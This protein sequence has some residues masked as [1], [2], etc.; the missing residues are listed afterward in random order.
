[1]MSKSVA[2]FIKS[3]QL[4]KYRKQEQLFLVEGLKSTLEVINSHFNVRTVLCTEQFYE[5]FS[6]QLKGIET[7]L[8]TENQLTDVGTLRS[9]NAA[10]AVVEIPV[11]KSKKL[12]TNK[13]YLALDDINDPGNLGTILRVA[14]WYGIDTI[15]ASEQTAELY[16]P[17]VISASKGSFTRVEVIYGDLER[18]ISESQLPV[19]GTLMEGDNIHKISFKKGCVIVFGNEANGISSKIKTLIDY[20]LT[21]PKIG[22][23]ESLNVAM[24]AAIVCDN[25]IRN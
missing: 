6:Q 20:K 21:I 12:D 14:D 16:N 9:N 1:M 2:K 8:V 15:L 11:A 10:L 22:G 23:A 3:L 13:F 19:Y 24:A 18:L 7:L 5:Q 25:A 17:K 4:K